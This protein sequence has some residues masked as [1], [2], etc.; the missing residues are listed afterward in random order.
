MTRGI[1]LVKFNWLLLCGFGFF[2]I[3]LIKKDLIS[4]FAKV[5]LEDCKS[6][7]INPRNFLD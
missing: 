4:D 2:G 1:L 5:N 6:N 7:F 3:N